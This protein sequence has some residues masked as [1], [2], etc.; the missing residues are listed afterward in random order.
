MPK[1]RRCSIRAWRS[2]TPSITT[3]RFDRSNKPPRLDPDCAMAYWGIAYANGLHI[4]KMVVTPDREKAA[5]AALAKADKA[6]VETPADRAMIAALA[7][8]YADKA[9]ADRTELNKA[10]SDAMQGVWK[11]FPNDADVGA[12]YAES[13]MNLRPWDLWTYRRQA[14]SGNGNG[15]G[16]ARSRPET[17]PE[18]SAR[19]APDDSRVGSLARRRTGRFP[20]PTACATCNRPSGIWCT[21]R[22]TSTFAPANGRRRSW[23]MR[24]P[25]SPTRPTGP[26]RRSRIFT[27]CT[28]PTITT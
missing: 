23:R 24:R 20:P 25:S 2:S 28:W 7:K 22:R 6:K 15:H 13:M 16:D 8:R 4:N 9:P 18:A 19:I 26:S 12:L 1:P 5:L 3:K 21:C 11:E 14:A 27:G 17:Q 10:Y